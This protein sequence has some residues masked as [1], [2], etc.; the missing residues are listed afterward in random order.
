MIL[1][2]TY[3]M[4]R[5]RD[6]RMILKFESTNLPLMLFG[7]MSTCSYDHVLLLKEPYRASDG[8]DHDIC[9]IDPPQGLSPSSACFSDTPWHRLQ[10]M[11]VPC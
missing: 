4:D 6:V 5:V 1:Q 10:C 3:N 9:A 7:K 11:H 8:P 2:L